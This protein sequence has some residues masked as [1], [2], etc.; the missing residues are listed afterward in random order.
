MG[1]DDLIALPRD[2]YDD[3]LAQAA[4]K[5]AMRALEE[6]GYDPKNENWVEDLRDGISLVRSL[7]DARSSAKKTIWQTFV[8]VLTIVIIGLA[9]AWWGIKIPKIPGGSL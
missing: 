2:D 6:I 9:L 1:S 5:G 7:K 3:V 8:R 4:Y